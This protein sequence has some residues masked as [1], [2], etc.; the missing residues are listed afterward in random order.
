M[1]N[2]TIVYEIII[3]LL[4][5]II[6]TVI[7][8]MIDIKFNHYQGISNI[9]SELDCS[10]SEYGCCYINTACYNNSNQIDYNKLYFDI[11][12]TERYRSNNCFEYH[13]WVQRYLA[14]YDYQIKKNF[15]HDSDIEYIVNSIYAI[16]YG[17][18]QIKF[19]CNEMLSYTIYT[20][21]DFLNSYLNDW[22]GHTSY[23]TH[24]AKIDN[25]GTECPDDITILS[26]YI[27][28]KNDDKSKPYIFI[29]LS[30]F[31]SFVICGLII[32]SKYYN[33]HKYKKL[34]EQTSN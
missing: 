3:F 21:N 10:S 14:D 22:N 31:G 7:T 2:H 8:I 23:K 15:V 25:T 32:I 4:S 12:N 6:F 26:H 24:I 30:S 18:C 11:I 1:K 9:E 28:A 13:L 27:N 16:K 17:Y 19:T 5:L 34:T 33:Q 29:R 20:Y